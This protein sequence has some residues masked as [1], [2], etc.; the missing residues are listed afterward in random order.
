MYNINKFEEIV[1]TEKFLNVLEKIYGNDSGIIGYQKLR[2]LSVFQLFKQQFIDQEVSLFS[3]PGRTE[4]GGNHTDHNHGKVL[5][6]SINLDAV[7]VAAKCSGRIITV[8][9]EGYSE[10]FIVNLDFLDKLDGEKGT[11][12]LLKGIVSGFQ[13]F[14]YKVGGFNAYLSSNVVNASGLSSSASIEMLICSILN[15]F[16]NQSQIDKVTYSK[17]GQYA[18]NYYWDKPSGL[19]DQMACAIGGMI[20]IDFETPD[21]PEVKEVSAAGLADNYDLIIVQTG[22]NHADLTN[23]YADITIEMKAIANALGREY[24]GELTLDQLMEALSR[25]RSNVG[26]RAVLRAIH[27]FQE[28]KR[29]I[30]QVEAIK[31]E[32]YERFFELISAS[33]DSSWK[34]L[35]NC[36]VPKS[37]EDQPIPYALALTELYLKSIGDG[38]CRVHGGGF[39]GVIQVFIP[40]AKSIKY[41]K[42]IESYLGENSTFRINIRKYGAV[43]LEEI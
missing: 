38:T 16:Y 22:G 15:S 25:I 43:N 21:L 30:E 4:I 37:V 42:Y 10:P 28:N 20:Y 19:L 12:P 35:Q 6:A 1:Q 41:I 32:N 27:F 36:Y 23:D 11:P 3:A 7:A 34:Y 31:T 39:A 40:K 13:K 17:I 14:G 26:D 8:Y 9:S 24:L 29:V 33:G 5:A 2:Y 18:E